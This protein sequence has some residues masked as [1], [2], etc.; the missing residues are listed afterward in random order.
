MTLSRSALLSTR[1]ETMGIR[2]DIGLVVIALQGGCEFAFPAALA[3][4]LK[5]ENP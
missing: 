2:A 3:E 4:G 1:G 5:S